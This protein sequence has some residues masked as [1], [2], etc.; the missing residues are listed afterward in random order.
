[1]PFKNKVCGCMCFRQNTVSGT[2]KEF[3]SGPENEAPDMNVHSLASR[4][5][6]MKEDCQ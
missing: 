2:Q 5:R 1:M 6:E 4:V 3:H